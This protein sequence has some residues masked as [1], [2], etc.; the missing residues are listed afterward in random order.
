MKNFKQLKIWQTGIEIVKLTYQLTRLFPN[1]EKFGLVSQM[2]R[3]A[4]SIPANIAEGN[5]RNSDKDTCRFLQI[6]LGS[7]FELQTYL[8]LAVELN[9]SASEH[10]NSLALL[11]ESEIRMIQQFMKTLSAN[12]Y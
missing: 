3:A 9:F 7:A 4:V 8:V 2:N 5:G 6:A 12:S 11:L 1:E 10:T